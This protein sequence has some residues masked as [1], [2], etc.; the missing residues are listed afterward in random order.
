MNCFFILI[1]IQQLN[2]KIFDN[3]QIIKLL[4]LFRRGLITHEQKEDRH[5]LTIVFFGYHEK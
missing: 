1:D 2:F 4:S 3:F 5:Y